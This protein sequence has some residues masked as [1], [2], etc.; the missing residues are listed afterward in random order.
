MAQPVKNQPSFKRHRRRGFDPWVRNIYP[1]EEMAA[2][3]SIL[4]WRIPWTEKPGGRQP[5]GRTE[6]DTTEATQHNI[7]YIATK[8]NSGFKSC[9]EPGTGVKMLPL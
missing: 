6:S 5:W 8:N 1:E 3:S 9:M 7:S 4:A 2:H